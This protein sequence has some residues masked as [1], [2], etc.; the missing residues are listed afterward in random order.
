MKGLV[1]VMHQWER[2]TWS[3]VDIPWNGTCAVDGGG[4]A[5]VAGVAGAGPGA[6]GSSADGAEGD[7]AG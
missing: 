3:S 4:R 1:M 2:S 6:Q 5:F 7:E